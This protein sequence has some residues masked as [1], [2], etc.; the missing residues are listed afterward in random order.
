MKKRGGENLDIRLVDLYNKKKKLLKGASDCS[1]ALVILI[2]QPPDQCCVAPMLTSRCFHSL[3]PLNA[4]ASLCTWI[5][6]S[7]TYDPSIL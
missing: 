2:G 1:P 6:T 5:H 7:P 4:A 3:G